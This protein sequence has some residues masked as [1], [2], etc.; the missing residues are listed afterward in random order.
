MTDLYTS[1]DTSVSAAAFGVGP[2]GV[3][4]RTAPGTPKEDDTRSTSR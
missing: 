3:F 4:D 1:A 2:H